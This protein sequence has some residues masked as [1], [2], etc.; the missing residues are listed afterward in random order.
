MKVR[1][2]IAFSCGIEY[3]GYLYIA[4]GFGNELFQ[5]DI[6]KQELKYLMDFEKEKDTGYLYRCIV[7]YKNKAC[8]IPQCAENIAIVNL[9]TLETSYIPLQYKWIQ[10]KI[11]LKCSGAGI[12]EDHFLFVIPYDIDAL[13]I[14]DLETLETKCY[15][16][17][18]DNTEPYIDAVYKE[19]FLYC[20][21]WMAEK[22]LQINLETE[23]RKMLDWPYKR[24]TY[25]EAIWDEEKGSMWLIPSKA[26]YLIK[27]NIEKKEIQKIQIDNETNSDGQDLKY[28]YGARHLS[29]IF[30]FPFK[31]EHVVAYDMESKQIRHYN[32][33][34]PEVLTPF[35]KPF[36]NNALW[37]VIERTN[38]LYWYNEEKDC[39]D[40]FPL[41]AD[42][43]EAYQKKIQSRL[44]EQLKQNENIIME[45]QVQR[46]QD[47]LEII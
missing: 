28:Y 3:K 16:D 45:N 19:G 21:P 30:V 9:D 1:A 44:K 25:S 42:Y 10:T 31:K 34:L 4:S 40:T 41:S 23:E 29:K 15:Y 18:S 7:L 35:F 47:F 38:R 26:S 27:Y 24:M 8:F 33:E 14:V 6:E 2:N 12:F 32:F 22:I 20:I 37:G 36:G 11:K 39:F 46:L 43:D 13:M 17:I 5:Y